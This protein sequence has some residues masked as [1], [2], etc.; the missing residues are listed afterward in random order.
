MRWRKRYSSRVELMG[1]G[2]DSFVAGWEKA[3]TETESSR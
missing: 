3:K 1:I 2:R